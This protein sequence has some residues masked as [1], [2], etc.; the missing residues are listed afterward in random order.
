DSILGASMYSLAKARDGFLTAAGGTIGTTGLAVR[1]AFENLEAL[2]NSLYLNQTR[3][4]V[5]S[6]LNVHN[7]GTGMISLM[8]AGNL[9]AQDPMSGISA[10]TVN[11]NVLGNTGT[12]DTL[13]PVMADRFGYHGIGKAFLQ[14]MNTDPDYVDLES[15]EELYVK[16]EGSLR[17]GSLRSEK[18]TLE[19]LEALGKEG[20]PLLLY[21][22][23]LEITGDLDKLFYRIL[24]YVKP[25]K[26]QDQEDG[27]EQVLLLITLLE[28]LKG[29]DNLDQTPQITLP[30]SAAA[31]ITR[32]RRSP[33]STEVTNT[34][35][36][37]IT[38]VLP[39]TPPRQ[40]QEETQ[41]PQQEDTRPQESAVLPDNSLIGDL[42]TPLAIWN[43]IPP[44]G[45]VLIILALAIFLLYA[46]T[47]RK[48]H[49][50]HLK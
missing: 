28:K 43:N 30:G 1:T 5:R 45:Q 12:F 11:L 35:P 27:D 32:G 13:Y 48:R 3:S 33:Q 41:T 6:I 16:A 2:G 14:I 38:P 29:E 31:A 42:M 24:K 18:L 19:V 21:T 9:S 34:T 44:Q 20:A 50:T 37:V 22:N 25:V 47:L 15:E 4:L 49:K 40:P 39:V 17:S 8:V 46:N 10:G 26:K 36:E 7:Y 23:L